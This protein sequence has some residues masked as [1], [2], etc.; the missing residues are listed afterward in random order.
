MNE[1]AVIEEV[2][3]VVSDDVHA[4]PHPNPK[5]HTTYQRHCRCCGE[6]FTTTDALRVY[7]YGHGRMAKMEK[8]C[9]C[10]CGE[11]FLTAKARQKYILGHNRE[12]RIALAPPRRPDEAVMTAEDRVPFAER[13]VI[14]RKPT[15]C[16]KCGSTAL[17]EGD[18]Y[19]PT[20]EDRALLMHWRCMMC[21]WRKWMLER[22]ER[23]R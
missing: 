4:R 12:G 16:G 23:V 7:A 14:N 22:V 18:H 3:E 20:A 19:A 21:G 5:L 9:A 10:G 2:Q 8:S 6:P 1:I 11:V 13:P 17:D 15:C